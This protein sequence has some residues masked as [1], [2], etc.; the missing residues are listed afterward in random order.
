MCKH[1]KT[2]LISLLKQPEGC[3]MPLNIIVERCKRLPRYVIY[4]F[5]CGTQ[6]AAIWMSSEIT[7]NVHFVIAPFHFPGHKTCSLAMQESSFA[8]L[9]GCNFESQEQRNSAIKLMERSPRAYKDVHFMHYTILAH[10]YQNLKATFRDLEDSS[11]EESTNQWGKRAWLKRIRE[12]FIT[13]QRT[14]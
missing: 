3:R 10:A 7:R 9:R 5:A 4:D 11:D 13:Q 14:S 12:A 1:A 2:V 8:D 6:R